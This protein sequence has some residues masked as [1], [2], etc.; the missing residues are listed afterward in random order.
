M[1]ES[2]GVG[3]AEDTGRP[4]MNCHGRQQRRRRCQRAALTL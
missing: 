1:M 2:A 3:R 4:A